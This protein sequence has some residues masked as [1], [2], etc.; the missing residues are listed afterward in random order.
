M[1]HGECFNVIDHLLWYIEHDLSSSNNIDKKLNENSRP[2]A[3]ITAC[4]FHG[5]R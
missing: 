3:Y 2:G 4:T 5:H 1:K